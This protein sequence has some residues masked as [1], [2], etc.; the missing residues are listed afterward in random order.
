MPQAKEVN[1]VPHA[2]EARVTLVPHLQH[3][4][5]FMRYITTHTHLFK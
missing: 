3:P 5:Q 1:E 2:S 4:H